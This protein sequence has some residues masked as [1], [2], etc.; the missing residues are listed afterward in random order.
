LWGGI[1]ERENLE[2]L[3]V[4]G[5]WNFGC[6]E[7]ISRRE[8]LEDQS[9]NGSWSFGC[10]EVSLSLGISKTSPSCPVLVS[11]PMIDF[12]LYVSP[13]EAQGLLRSKEL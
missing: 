8:H 9:V 3:S 6:G 5:S 2:D 7:G 13:R 4:N 12:V 10:E 11:Q 1:N